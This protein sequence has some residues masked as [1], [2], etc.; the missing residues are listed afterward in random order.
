MMTDCALCTPVAPGLAQF[1]PVLGIS[2]DEPADV[3]GDE[4]QAQWI[5]EK[6][7]ETKMLLK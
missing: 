5:A 4:S 2:R 7:L 3:L 1:C 6:R